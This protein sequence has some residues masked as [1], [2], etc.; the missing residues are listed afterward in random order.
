M[1]NGIAILKTDH[2]VAAPKV[3]AANFKDGQR[4]RQKSLQADL[5][6]TADSSGVKGFSWVWT[7]NKDKEPSKKIT[8]DPENTKIS[9]EAKKDGVWYLKVRQT[10]YAG[11]WSDSSVISYNLSCFYISPF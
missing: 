5:K 11:N 2:S 10:D 4:S 8:N 6:A 9:M 7:Q 1:E 3:F